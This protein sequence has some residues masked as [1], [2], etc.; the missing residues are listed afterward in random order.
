MRLRPRLTL[1]AFLL[2]LLPPAAA[3]AQS[4]IAPPGNAGV[5]EYVEVVPSADGPRH[6]RSDPG[7]GGGVP[8]DTEQRLGE[9]G[10]DG[11]AVVQLAGGSKTGKPPKGDQAGPRVSPGLDSGSES[12]P[13]AVVR[14]VTDASGGMGALFPA[15]LAAALFAGGLAV[16]L[17]RRAL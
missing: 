12:V 8:A 4:T 1:L 17:R 6:G 10:A 15:V 7:A 5:D 9:Q 13:A 2:V 16:L 14:A 11:Q 3:N